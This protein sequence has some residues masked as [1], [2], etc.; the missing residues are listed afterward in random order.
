MNYTTPYDLFAPTSLWLLARK[1]EQGLPVLNEDLAILVEG[2]PDAANDSLVCEYLVRGLRGDLKKPRGRKALGFKR[3][4]KLEWATMCVEVLTR[5]Y[6]RAREKGF[7]YAPP[8]GRSEL[9]LSQ[10]VHEK[11]ASLLNL[12]T[13]ESL[14]N[15]LCAHKKKWR[16]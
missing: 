4:M 1:H 6:K 12:G 8:K 10:F 15:A 3:M 7:S 16:F 9:G 11:V 5:R 13:G 2:N 14:A